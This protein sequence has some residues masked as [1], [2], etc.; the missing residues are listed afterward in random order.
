MI[1]PPGYPKTTS[2]PSRVRTSQTICAPVLCAGSAGGLSLCWTAAAGGDDMRTSG[3]KKN[4]TPFRV[5]GPGSFRRIFFGQDGGHLA[6]SRFF[7]AFTVHSDVL[8][9]SVPCGSD[10]RTEGKAPVSAALA[11][12]LPLQGA[13]QVLPGRGEPPP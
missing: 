3:A 1:A 6:F 7:V 10:P 12:V 13:A 4:P 8:V 5:R 11:L 9:G 2:T